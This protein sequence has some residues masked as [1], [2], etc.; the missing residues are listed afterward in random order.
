MIPWWSN[1]IAWYKR[2]PVQASIS[3]KK[4]KKNSFWKDLDLTFIVPTA[5][6]HI[7]F[8]C[9]QKFCVILL[10]FIQDIYRNNPKVDCWENVYIIQKQESVLI[11]GSVYSLSSI[12]VLKKVWTLLLHSCWI[13]QTFISKKNLPTFPKMSNRSDVCCLLFF[14]TCRSVPM[15]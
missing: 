10:W 13:D 12:P 5:V 2:S 9:K 7:G 3:K 14:L 6:C 11:D 4:R 8:A 1:V 15:Y